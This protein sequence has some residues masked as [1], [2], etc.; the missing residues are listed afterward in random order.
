MTG[1]AGTG[2]SSGGA[3]RFPIFTL[4]WAWPRLG[5]PNS[6]KMVMPPKSIRRSIGRFLLLA[7]RDPPSIR[8]KN[9]TGVPRR[10]SIVRE[11]VE[12]PGTTRLFASGKK[13]DE[14]AA[15]MRGGPRE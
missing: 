2:T 3:G 6:I 4:T 12:H 7:Y 5:R 14:P 10:L 11:E 8:L 15:P 9:A 1:V 13:V